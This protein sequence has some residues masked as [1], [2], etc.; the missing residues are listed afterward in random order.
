[1]VKLPFPDLVAVN[2]DV[3]EETQEIMNCWINYLNKNQY[4]DWYLIQFLFP[5]ILLW[6][7]TSSVDQRKCFLKPCISKYSLSFQTTPFSSHLGE[8][9]KKL[10]PGLQPGLT[11]LEFWGR[12]PWILTFTKFPKWPICPWMFTHRI[13]YPTFLM[14]KHTHDTQYMVRWNWNTNSSLFGLDSYRFL[15]SYG[16]F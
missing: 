15:V 13:I 11:Q 10:I 12:S 6:F 16:S 9:L 5:K 4:D 7:V 8:V 1:M 14:K 3:C 2:V